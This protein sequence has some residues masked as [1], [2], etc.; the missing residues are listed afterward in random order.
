MAMVQ[1]RDD[2]GWVQLSSSAVAEIWSSSPYILYVE[3]INFA[4]GLNVGY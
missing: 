4:D 2:G 3:V 1:V